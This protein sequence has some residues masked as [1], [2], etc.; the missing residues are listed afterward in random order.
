MLRLDSPAVVG[1]FFPFMFNEIQTFLCLNTTSITPSFNIV[2]EYLEDT[3]NRFVDIYELNML[4]SY[5]GYQ[6]VPKRGVVKNLFSH[7]AIT[8]SQFNRLPLKSKAT[9]SG[10]FELM[11]RLDGLRVYE[12]GPD[13]IFLASPQA[14]RVTEILE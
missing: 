2:P 9:Q 5:V 4:G 12:Y 14:N 8:T 6:I 1:M 10:K 13:G 7:L 11:F 3:E